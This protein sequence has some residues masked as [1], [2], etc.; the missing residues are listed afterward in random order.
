MYS[1]CLKP[2]SA[3]AK[4]N[5]QPGNYLLELDDGRIYAGRQGPRVARLST[6]VRERKVF[7]IRFRS[8]P[9]DDPCLRAERERAAF[10]SVPPN[11]RA[12]KIVPSRPA[13]CAISNPRLPSRATEGPGAGIA[14]GIAAGIALV[15]LSQR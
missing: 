12:N 1:T 7:C 15:I 13:K 10:D 8:N 3:V 4:F 2:K 14:L 11:R 9:S 6:H 5:G